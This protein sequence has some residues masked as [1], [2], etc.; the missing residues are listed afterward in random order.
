MEY[1][2]GLMSHDRSVA[3]CQYLRV[4]QQLPPAVLQIQVWLL[5]PGILV[6]GELGRNLGQTELC[7]R[8]Q[9]SLKQLHT[10]HFLKDTK[11]I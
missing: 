3:V 10:V 1:P 5:L 11:K 6:E 8:L 9:L 2:M 4:V 7:V